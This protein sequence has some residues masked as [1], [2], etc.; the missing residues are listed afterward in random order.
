MLQTLPTMS[1]WLEKDCDGIYIV[2]RYIR[3]TQNGPLSMRKKHF[4]DLERQVG[5][6]EIGS[7]A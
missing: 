1:N 6:V 3:R 4:S 2:S 5:G 7:I